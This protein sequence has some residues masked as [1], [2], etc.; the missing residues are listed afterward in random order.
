MASSNDVSKGIA[1]SAEHKP[2]HRTSGGHQHDSEAHRRA[3]TI[4]DD[5]DDQPM[6]SAPPVKTWKQNPMVPAGVLGGGIALAIGVV[7]AQ[8]SGKT[9]GQKIMEARVLAQATAV[10]GLFA[11]AAFGL[12][13][14]DKKADAQSELH[15]NKYKRTGQ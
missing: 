10:A 9:I 12:S 14:S 3:N 7:M 2:G 5:S 11:A 6:S 4:H 15:R 8:R 13:N 1:S